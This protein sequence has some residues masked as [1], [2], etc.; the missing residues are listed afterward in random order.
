M[1]DQTPNP[2]PA[3]TSSSV[4]RLAVFHR[5]DDVL[6]HLA[7]L[8]HIKTLE[9][10]IV[11]QGT[12]WTPP[13]DV[14]GI[15]WE[16]APQDAGDGRIPA[17]IDGIPSAS[18]SFATNPALVDV[19]KAIGF[20]R[21]LS[22]PI[23][24]IDVERALTLPAVVDLADRLEAG[25]PKLGRLSKRTEAVSELLRAVNASTDPA[26]VAAALVARVSD[27]LPLMRP[28]LRPAALLVSGAGMNPWS[29]VR[30]TT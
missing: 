16:L 10:V 30:T 15:L 25:G 14:A 1:P 28:E 20:R 8:S 18:Y 23:R 27:W 12:T 11:W 9:L 6:D 19:S 26:G 22:T 2:S 7:P 5:S 29:A 17:L 21:H 24:M 3:A 4:L 13:R